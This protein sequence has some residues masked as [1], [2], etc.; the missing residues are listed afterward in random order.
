M[1]P[2]SI[3]TILSVFNQAPGGN[4]LLTLGIVICALCAWRWLS[5]GKDSSHAETAGGKMLTVASAFGMWIGIG[6]VVI[7]VLNM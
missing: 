7:G 4:M 3:S 1:R 5:E 6:L 2:R